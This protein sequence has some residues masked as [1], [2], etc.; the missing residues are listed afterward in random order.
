VDGGDACRR[1]RFL[2]ATARA[3]G[4]SGESL[5]LDL[6]EPRVNHQPPGLTE[7]ASYEWRDPER[8]DVLIRGG[9]APKM[10]AVAAVYGALRKKNGVG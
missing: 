2:V 7:Q 3:A 1:T 8:A 4:A 10:A 5:S 6:A 9:A